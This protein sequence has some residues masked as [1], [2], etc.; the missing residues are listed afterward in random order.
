MN[1]KIQKQRVIYNIS[2]SKLI[3]LMLGIQK[4]CTELRKEH[5]PSEYF[6]DPTP[7][8]ICSPI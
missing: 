2:C 1:L 7:N 8:H 6:L 3:N 5:C 4:C